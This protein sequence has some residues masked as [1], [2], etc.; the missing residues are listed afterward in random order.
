M[1]GIKLLIRELVEY[2]KNIIVSLARAFHR[3]I[4]KI[5]EITFSIETYILSVIID[6]GHAIYNLRQLTLWFVLLPLSL[7]GG[8][9]WTYSIFGL[10]WMCITLLS[11]FLFW[12][13]I[14]VFGL[15]RFSGAS[16]H[17]KN[18]EEQLSVLLRLK[19]LKYARW[20]LRIIISA[21]I[22]FTYWF[23]VYSPY[24]WQQT[25]VQ[26]NSDIQRLSL[27]KKNN[28]SKTK[29]LKKEN[30]DQSQST[31]QKA[32]ILPPKKIEDIE[33]TKLIKKSNSG[34]GVSPKKNSTSKT[35]YSKKEKP[36]QSQ[37]TI[38]KAIIPPP[39]KIEDI[40]Q[41]KLIKKSNS[42]EGVSPKKNST[43]KTKYSKKEKPNQSQ[44]TIQKAIIPPPKKNPVIKDFA[45]GVYVYTIKETKIREK[46]TL[47]SKIL[48][49]INANYRLM[50]LTNENEN[51]WFMVMMTPHDPYDKRVG[52]WIHRE[53]FEVRSQNKKHVKSTLDKK[54]SRTY[55]KLRDP[56][57][58]F[59]K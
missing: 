7:L 41:T 9:Y 21:A 26:M 48:G 54:K 31:I 56:S 19:I 37:S 59:S 32:I 57:D 34:E 50:I 39:K 58:W 51:E 44:S 43:S 23:N 25:I 17:E 42:S 5:A 30:P 4:V 1:L 45:E 11:L 8:A 12:A 53:S 33:Q 2:A 6:G 22:M 13:L 49:T 55:Y 3:L 38:Q 46:P 28:T 29:S 14:I 10:G 27:S 24:N 47:Q 36:N 20:P 52:G 15:R 40:K 16:S 35:K 18:I